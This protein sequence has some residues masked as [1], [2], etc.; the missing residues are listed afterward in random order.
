M[1]TAFKNLIHKKEKNINEGDPFDVIPIKNAKQAFECEEIH[2][3]SRNV[4]KL[5]Q[6]DKFPN[7]EVLWLNDNKVRSYIFYF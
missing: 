7:L 4:E 3:G 1:K 5:V 2:L 6:F